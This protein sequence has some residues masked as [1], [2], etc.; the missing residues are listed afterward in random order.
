MNDDL[1]TSNRRLSQYEKAVA[2][3][4]QSNEKL[5]KEI[6]ILKM[7]QSHET[8]ASMPDLSGNINN[9]RN[10]MNLNHLNHH[11]NDM[12]IS[13]FMASN[14]NNSMMNNNNNNNNGMNYSQLLR[15]QSTGSNGSM[16]G[17]SNSNSL[18]Y[19]VSNMRLEDQ[20]EKKTES[21]SSNSGISSKRVLYEFVKMHK[22]LPKEFNE[23]ANNAL[24]QENDDEASRFVRILLENDKNPQFKKDIASIVSKLQ[25][26]KH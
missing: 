16:P 20:N 19:L 26:K 7:Q 18:E 14:Q 6:E 1:E 5:M 25:S 15:G 9:N 17:M 2:L 10:N 4:K 23:M 24:V 8:F 11:S 22:D 3:L 21:E 13:R 12:D